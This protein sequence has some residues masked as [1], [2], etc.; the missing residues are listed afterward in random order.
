MWAN[1]I[2]IYKP[3]IK[4]KGGDT[5]DDSTSRDITGHGKGN[6]RLGVR[7]N[8]VRSGSVLYK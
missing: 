7:S 3:I 1:Y 8:A 4:L 2:I 5:T 6:D